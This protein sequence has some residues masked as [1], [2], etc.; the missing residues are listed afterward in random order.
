MGKGRAEREKKR[1][2]KFGKRGKSRTTV[3]SYLGLNP[4]TFKI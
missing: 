4:Q 1:D 3:S 2:R